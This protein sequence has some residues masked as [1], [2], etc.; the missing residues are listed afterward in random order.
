MKVTELDGSIKL[1]HIQ[2]NEDLLRRI[3]PRLKRLSSKL[4]FSASSRK[5][6]ERLRQLEQKLVKQK[7]ELLSEALRL[8]NE[9]D[10]RIQFFENENRSVKEKLLEEI[11]E[12]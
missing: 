3:V 9:F 6:E 12:V 2:K 8:K 10:N 4:S 11:G 1:E 7:K 5:Q